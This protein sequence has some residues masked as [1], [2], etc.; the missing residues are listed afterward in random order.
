MAWSAITTYAAAFS[1]NVQDTSTP[2]SNKPGTIATT[3]AVWIR[4]QPAP[5]EHPGIPLLSPSLGVFDGSRA[6]RRWELDS[7]CSDVPKAQL[8]RM[9][10]GLILLGSAGCV[11][12]DGIPRRGGQPNDR[13]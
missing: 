11:Y 7:L 4:C 1:C 12:P 8:T 5:Y 13:Y 3:T 10:Q 9:T 6:D 2:N